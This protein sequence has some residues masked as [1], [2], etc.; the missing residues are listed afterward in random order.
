MDLKWALLVCTCLAFGAASPAEELPSNGTEIEQCDNE[1][2]NEMDRKI[3]QFEK[4]MIKL[5]LLVNE[6]VRNIELLDLCKANAT[7][8]DKANADI[9]TELKNQVS[10]L[11]LSIES[12]KT[13]L[14][15]LTHKSLTNEKLVVE[16]QKEIAAKDE[17]IK[18]LQAQVTEQSKKANPTIVDESNEDKLPNSCISYGNA[19]GVLKIKVPRLLAFDVLCD[20]T[21]A[22]PGW[23]IIQRRINGSE[24]FNRSWNAYSE[25]FGSRDGEFFLGLQKI[26]R[27]T[28]D[29]RHELY[30]KMENF[31][32]IIEFAK[33][34]Q[35]AVASERDH[36]KLLSLGSFSGNVTEDHLTPLIYSKF[37]TSDRVN[38]ACAATR[39]G[40]WWFQDCSQT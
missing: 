16:S 30:I 27:V 13:N 5:E 29:Q 11:K 10:E 22:G 21:T 17:K 12:H 33:Y 25:G 20:T 18:E 39:Q 15:T 6:G 3:N 37:S 36:F 35:F 19:T 40:G 14:E 26:H 9:I 7:K 38:D 2:L 8:S 31:E 23:T 32:G 34:D 4:N 1:K 24:N 28:M